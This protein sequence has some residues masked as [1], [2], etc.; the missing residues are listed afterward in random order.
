MSSSGGAVNRPVLLATGVGGGLLSGLLGGGGGAIMIPLMTGALKMRQHTA[1]GTS[2]VI[3]TFA[4]LASA[5]TYALNEHV[6]IRLVGILLA[7]SAGGAYFGARAAGHLNAMRLRQC[8]GL[9]LLAVCARLLFLRDLDPLFGSTGATEV[10]VGAGIGLAGGLASGALGVGGGAIFV[11]AMV[12]LLGTGQHEAQGIS[13]WV[14]V[15]SSAV[16]A[17]THS[18]HGTIDLAAARWIIPVAVPAGVA[19]SILAAAMSRDALQT[20]FA[21][22]L[23]LIGLQMLVTA[24]R[25]LRRPGRTSAPAALG[26]DAA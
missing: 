3:I 26:A 10:A 12:L 11:P 5:I 2:L 18:R 1:H 8:L 4:A 6:D 9:F 16:G 24:T 15:V 20:T 13:L 22:L 17:F 25:R 23:S 7:G 14:I 21:I 19:G